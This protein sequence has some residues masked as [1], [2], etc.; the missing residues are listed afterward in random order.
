M[1]LFAANLHGTLCRR[2]VLFP[3][4]SKTKNYRGID[5]I[6]TIFIFLNFQQFCWVFW[7]YH[8]WSFFPSLCVF[9]LSP[10]DS[11]AADR[12]N[13]SISYKTTNDNGKVY[14]STLYFFR[15]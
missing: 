4:A 8:N 2:S 9:L 12:R 15:F 7:I 13:F 3:V 14:Y 1:R 6:Y 10:L 11:F 5:L